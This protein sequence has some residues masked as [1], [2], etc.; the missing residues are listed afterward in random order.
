MCSIDVLKTFTPEQREEFY[1][2]KWV[3]PDDPSGIN[4]ALQGEKTCKLSRLFK[5]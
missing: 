3:L 5:N 2:K 4:I 1:M